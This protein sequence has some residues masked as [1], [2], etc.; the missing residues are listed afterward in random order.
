[1]ASEMSEAS[2]NS[3]STARGDLK[4]NLSRKEREVSILNNKLIEMEKELAQAR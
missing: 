4:D 2:M 3:T 1:M